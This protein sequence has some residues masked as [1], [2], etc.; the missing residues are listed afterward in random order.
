MPRCGA[1]QGPAGPRRLL[2][3]KSPPYL[4]TRR[5]TNHGGRGRAIDNGT[6]T[7]VAAH[8]NGAGGKGTPRSALSP[9]LPLTRPRPRRPRQAASTT[10]RPPFAALLETAALEDASEPAHAPADTQNLVPLL[11]ELSA[12]GDPRLRW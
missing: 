6:G 1:D 5:G 3:D 12:L 7:S 11:D 10:P 8:G 9:S 2:A 4:P